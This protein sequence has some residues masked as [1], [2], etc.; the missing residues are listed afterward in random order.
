MVEVS[1]R[2]GTPS[3]GPA[4]PSPSSLTRPTQIRVQGME[5]RRGVQWVEARAVEAPQAAAPQPEPQRN[6]AEVAATV[7]PRGGRDVELRR[8][9]NRGFQAGLRAAAK[10]AA[11][12]HGVE[13]D[14]ADE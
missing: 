1:G 5:V 11:P 4:P 2:Y 14:G 12:G 8:A 7:G 3:A 13:Q 6:S 10:K 9:Y